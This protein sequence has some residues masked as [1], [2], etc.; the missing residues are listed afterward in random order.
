MPIIDDILGSKHPI[1]EKWKDTW[2]T[3]ERR[4]EGGAA[5]FEE[6]LAPF[7]WETKQ[8]AGKAN[9][10]I[11]K[12]E[13][14]Y[15]N[16]AKRMAEKFVGA[17]SREAPQPGRGLDLEGLGDVEDKD[18]PAYHVLHSIDSA[19]NDGAHMVSFFDSVQKAAMGTGHRW[20]FVDLPKI[21]TVPSVADEEAGIRPYVVEFSPI[22]VPD[23]HYSD[24]RLMYARIEFD[25]RVPE[26]VE[27]E[28]KSET[29]KRHLLL[30]AEGW[31]GFGPEYEGGG[32]WLY[33]N[34]KKLVKEEDREMH[35]PWVSTEGE[36]PL[37]PFYYERHKKE[38][39]RSGLMEILQVNVAHM[40]LDSAG[41]YDAIKSGSRRLYFVGA[42]STQH[43][44]IR[45]QHEAASQ[46]ISIPANP[47]TGKTPTIWDTGMVSAN[48]AIEQRLAKKAEYAAFIA[49]DELTT[50][51]G[52]SG[53]AREIDFWDTKSP[54]L[55]LM[56]RE[57]GAGENGVFRYISMRWGKDPSTVGVLWK[58]DYDIRPVADDIRE[59][60]EVFS[61]VGMSSPSASADL[62]VQLMTEK[63]LF[64]ENLE[65]E[66]VRNELQESVIQGTQADALLQST[67]DEE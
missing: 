36:I 13:A 22:D 45:E 11:R 39:S 41:D 38:F 24:G 23:W 26:V 1:W 3:I 49:M 50:G 31:L 9:F 63:G 48:D 29:K 60:F 18:S 67:L 62:G 58:E 14:N 25:V 51:P 15:I 43:D 5:V 59:V 19:G 52:D 33:D 34:D 53:V 56:A 32:W 40:N 30:V 17:L 4:M 21:D 12:G 44:K 2:E 55:A 61:E 8:E 57:R 20:L 66:T 37:V 27:G 28:F 65:P 54:R 6:D 35:S 47:V 42:D 16:F 64:H 10:E 7:D 46:G